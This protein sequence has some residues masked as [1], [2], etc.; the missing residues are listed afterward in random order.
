MARLYEP[1]TRRTRAVARG[2]R[3][4]ADLRWGAVHHRVDAARLGDAM[5][6]RSRLLPLTAA[7]ALLL[8]TAALV[9]ADATAP[10]AAPTSRDGADRAVLRPAAETP[11][12]FDDTAGGDADADDPA[13]WVH[14]RRV[15]RSV[16]LGTLKNGGLDAYDLR[17]RRLQHVDTPTA[18][19]PDLEAGRFNNV[20]L[21]V[22]SRFGD[23][24]V[25]TDRGRDRLRFYRVD[26]RGTAA[27]GRVLTDVTAGGVPRLFSRTEAAVE[28]QRTGYGLAVRQTGGTTYAIASRRSTSTLG[29]VRLVRS[30]GGDVTYRRTALLR[31]PA[32][33]TLRSGVRWSPCTDPGDGPQVEGMVV[34]GVRDVLYAAQED[35]GV[36][37]I[38]LEGR[39]F[40]RPTLV[41][42][43][44]EF[45][46]TASYDAQTEEC[47]V[48]GGPLPDSG[49]HLSADAEGLTLVE[50][51]GRP[52]QLVVSSQG[53]STFAVLGLRGRF[54]RT[55][56][57]G[58]RGGID[59]DQ[60][61]DGA[62]LVTTPMG[63]RYPHGLLVVQDGE[64]RPDVE[65]D[66]EVRANSNFKLV[67]WR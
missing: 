20:D 1:A 30:R 67:P 46:R 66:G 25:V 47:V 38:P 36:W 57:I 60:H 9:P 8:G 39:G 45:G 29:M 19:G 59:G 31:L 24:A 61:S 44:R 33:F 34:D 50:R 35:V 14:P 32:T 6:T 58:A 12:T 3:R 21:A 11:P 40:G 27:G 51:D 2:A 52:R 37:R 13:I 42:R 63:P 17:G 7:V 28:E 43:V 62:A 55:F 26:A 49:R 53:D 16:V 18:P 10:A 56:T 23:L 15:G 48:T 22:D 41:Q 65:A 64:N 5:T 4:V 54:V